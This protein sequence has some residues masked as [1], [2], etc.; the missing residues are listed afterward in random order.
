M[1]PLPS[2]A[3]LLELF[4]YDPSHPMALRWRAPP[5]RCR[6]GHLAGTWLSPKGTEKRYLYVRLNGAMVGVHRVV[7]KLH[8]GDEPGSLRF[9]DDGRGDCRIERLTTNPAP[10]KPNRFERA[11]GRSAYFH[12]KYLKAAAKR[13]A[14]NSATG[15]VGS[16]V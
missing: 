4:T 2:Q 5:R 13:A 15:E 9:V 12:M 8:H 10:H 7:W 11:G 1:S 16:E 3:E 14:A 6:V